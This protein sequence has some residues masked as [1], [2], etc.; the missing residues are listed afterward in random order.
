[1][2][3]FSFE[4]L[5]L[6]LIFLLPLYALFN[7][8]DGIINLPLGNK[9]SFFLRDFLIISIFL[10]A[11]KDMLFKN[12]NPSFCYSPITKGVFFVFLIFVYAFFLTLFKANIELAFK[13]FHIY[14]FHITIFFSFVFFRKKINYHK[15]LLILS[16][17]G[18]F[19]TLLSYYFYFQRP[20]FFVNIF[21]NFSNLGDAT[22]Y[23]RN[24]GIFLSPLT[25]SLFLGLLL[26]IN[27][28]Y[29]I[30]YKDNWFLLKFFLTVPALILT[31]SRGAWVA[32]FVVLIVISY[33]NINISKKINK[34]YFIFF[35]TIFSIY[36]F[37]FLND[38]L[39][40]FLIENRFH[41]IFNFHSDAYSRVSSWQTVFDLFENNFFG[42]GIGYGSTKSSG[43]DI[44]VI[45]GFYVQLIAQTGILGILSHLFLFFTI[46]KTI[47][48]LKKNVLE[49]NL[50]IFVEIFYAFFLFILI[51]SIGSTPLD[52]VNVA[53]YFWIFLGVL[54]GEVVRFY[55][56]VS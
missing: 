15:I 44:G 3:L 1:M 27:I 47:K 53:P 42:H 5:L 19:I 51:Q 30:Y 26:I 56:R 14:F 45:D 7:S 8:L 54:E 32:S 50:I 25:F 29:Y 9:L 41:S 55:Y 28:V 49:L 24:V 12:Y 13:S 34:F 10:C 31:F 2:K 11:I 35:S 4:N 22:N 40:L 17:Y 16:N 36:L 37:Y 18:L 21:N 52:F 43:G 33:R 20:V 23:V 38:Q 48:L 46:F 6:Y 39:Y